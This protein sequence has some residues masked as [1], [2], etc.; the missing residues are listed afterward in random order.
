MGDLWLALAS[1]ARMMMITAALRA[2]GKRGVWRSKLVL[3]EQS[4]AE[5]VE[6]PFV[7]ITI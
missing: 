2:Q 7:T 3:E 1:L 6:F 4:S 5:V